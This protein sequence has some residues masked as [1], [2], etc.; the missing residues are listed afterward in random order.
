MFFTSQKRQW[1]ASQVVVGIALKISK[2][3]S[4]NSTKIF[5]I[6]LIIVSSLAPTLSIQPSLILCE[7]SYIFILRAREARSAGME[8]AADFEI[9]SDNSNFTYL[10]VIAFNDLRVWLVIIL[11]NYLNYQFSKQFYPMKLMLKILL[12]VLS[13]LKYCCKV[14]LCSAK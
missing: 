10:L 5:G 9:A 1:S 11:E 13:S 6:S 2:I 12:N 3:I 4:L 7:V 14:L 8:G